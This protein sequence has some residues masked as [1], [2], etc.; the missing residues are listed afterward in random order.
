[1]FFLH[2]GLGNLCNY[3]CASSDSSKNLQFTNYLEPWGSETSNT[4]ARTHDSSWKRPVYVKVLG[5][6]QHDAIRSL[7]NGSESYCNAGLNNLLV[8]DD[9]A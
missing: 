8:S 9:L 1:V 7:K 3:F 2:T 6:M 4:T 5:I